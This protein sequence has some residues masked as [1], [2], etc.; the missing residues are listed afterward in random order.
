[1]TFGK[2]EGN[3]EGEGQNTPASGGALHDYP[4][5]RTE[6]GAAPIGRLD[7]DVSQ[8]FRTGATYTHSMGRAGNLAF[9]GVFTRQSGSVYSRTASVS[10]ADIPEYLNEGSYT[11]Y[12][13]GRGVAR[14]DSWWRADLSV[15]Y[16]IKVWKGVGFWTKVSAL[17]VTGEDT[18]VDFNGLNED[19]G[20][21]Q[22]INGVLTWVPSGNCTFED[23][24]SPDC[25]GF[26][27]VRNENDYQAP[28][29]MLL[30][31]GFTWR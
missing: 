1:M 25:T 24:P 13:G 10:F 7:E 27:R 2:I 22:T 14:L 26:G 16:N 20:S 12:F 31:A 3:F 21:A 15:R 17:N 29:T 6:E 28:R 30:T 8:R 23:K 4:R 11:H 5:A 19:A 9:G 18:I